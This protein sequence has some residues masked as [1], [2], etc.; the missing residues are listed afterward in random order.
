MAPAFDV[1]AYGGPNEAVDRHFKVTVN[2]GKLN[3]RL[4]GRVENPFLCAVEIQ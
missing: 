1:L 2:D 3:V 4:V